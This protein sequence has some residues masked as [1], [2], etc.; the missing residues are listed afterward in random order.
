[1]AKFKN[2]RRRSGPRLPLPANPEPPDTICF[3]VELPYD[4]AN[5]QESLWWIATFTGQLRRLG[6]R[7]EYKE[8]ETDAAFRTARTWRNV[9]EQIHQRSAAGVYCD[10]IEQPEEGEGCFQVGAFH[11]AI[12]YNPNHPILSPDAAPVGPYGVACWTTGAGYIFADGNDGMV[13]P[14]CYTGSL[15]DILAYGAPSVTISFSGVGEVDVHFL[16]QPQGGWAWVFP[17]GNPLLGVAVDLSFANI[18]D[19]ASVEFLLTL[20]GLAS[21]AEDA[22]VVHTMNFDTPGDHTITAWFLP[23][24]GVEPPF[25]GA[26][27][28]LRKVQFCGE[29]EVETETVMPYS[30]VLNG[31]DLEL[32]LDGSVVSSVQ[33]MTPEPN[34]NFEDTV[35]INNPENGEM[36]YL[37]F[38][39]GLGGSPA[40]DRARIVW[41]M[42]TGAGIQTA[43]RLSG[44]FENQADLTTGSLKIDAF[45][46]GNA[47]NVV[48]FNASSRAMELRLDPDLGH[49]QIARFVQSGGGLWSNSQFLFDIF[50]GQRLLAV[51]ASG[52]LE[53][54]YAH[55]NAS[56]TSA[57]TVTA[58][59]LT[60]GGTS[61]GFGFSEVKQA[62]TSTGAVQSLGR[63]SWLWVN[64]TDA[65]RKGG[66]QLELFDGATGR[67]MIDA[68]IGPSGETMLGYHG[69]AAIPR[70]FVTGSSEYAV[71]Q[72]LV[73][74][75]HAAGHIND[76]TTLVP[77]EGSSS[78]VATKTLV[79][80][81][82]RN[83]E[84]GQYSMVAFDDDYASYVAAS[85]WENDISGLRV[86][87]NFAADYG[88]VYLHIRFHVTCT[89]DTEIA[90]FLDWGQA[91]EYEIWRET[92]NTGGVVTL[93]GRTLPVYIRPATTTPLSFVT[94]TDRA[95]APAEV[96]LNSLYIA[97]EGLV[98]HEDIEINPGDVP[99]VIR[100]K[101]IATETYSFYSPPPTE[102]ITIEEQ[103]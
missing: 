67:K 36:P 80:E 62:A 95:Y 19:L 39:G 101:D 26:G 28:G 8:G 47:R 34:C 60:G 93:F 17:D 25:I 61:N 13:N 103:T 56:G 78:L 18:L 102:P 100:Y 27:G 40:N 94:L 98:G 12:H 49:S 30:L 82:F 32:V 76:G 2:D 91:Y 99:R 97:Y 43:L 81:V 63:V 52:R 48:T 55:T 44:G 59:R 66:W 7:F 6:Y 90:M 89:V 38:E 23:S 85:G 16:S 70:P 87:D 92:F 3:P 53:N 29:I 79:T 42:D 64:A 1:M 5:P 77:D 31:C 46:S 68:A 11:P 33:V 20:L 58:A 69:N 21:G 86:Y 72:S 9:V 10:D 83:F 45:Y 75:L 73:A 4:Y 96:V 71:L 24:A 22:E 41:N 54:L 65:I 88:I 15:A 37:I 57:A 51:R 50:N 84:A 35:T 14:L 74:G